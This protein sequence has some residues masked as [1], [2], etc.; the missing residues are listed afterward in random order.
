MFS[1]LP[2]KGLKDFVQSVIDDRR[3][4]DGNPLLRVAAET[5]KLLGNTSYEYNIMNRSRH[6]I[7][8]NLSDEKTHKA[9]NESLF[10]N[11]ITIDKDFY[12]VDLLKSTIE[13]REPIIL[14]FLSYCGIQS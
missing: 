12:E 7:T 6:K 13:H 9:I 3:E 5:M 8:R 10:K 2:Q 4:G 11:L 1:I 14:V